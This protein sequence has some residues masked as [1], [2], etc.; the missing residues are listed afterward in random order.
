MGKERAD[1]KY[2]NAL[3]SCDFNRAA[4]RRLRGEFSQSAQRGSAEFSMRPLAARL[5]AALPKI[6]RCIA[7]GNAV[8]QARC[9][10]S[11]ALN[12]PNPE[13]S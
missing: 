2:R 3:C 1:L 13:Q 6:T 5:P 7:K 4:V 9:S 10:N 8:I 12:L 11:E